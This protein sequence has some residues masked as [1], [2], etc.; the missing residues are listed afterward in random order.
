MLIFLLFP[1]QI[2]EGEKSL[3]GEVPQGASH[4]GRKPDFVKN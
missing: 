2:S 1:D 4:C 3:R